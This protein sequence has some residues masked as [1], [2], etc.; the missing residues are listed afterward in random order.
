MAENRFSK[1]ATG[2]NRFQQYQA[3]VLSPE[4]IARREA[5]L[6]KRD[7]LDAS[8]QDSTLGGMAS[9]IGS[10]LDDNVRLAANGISFGFLDKA[11]GAEDRAK[12]NAARERQGVTG[13]ASE[14]L[15]SMALP[16][17]AA[18]AG[19]SVANIPLRGA[20]LAAPTV[21][22]AGYG[23]LSALGNDK[24]VGEGAAWGAGLGMLG[25]AVGA[26]VNKA[27][28]MFNKPKVPTLEGLTAQKTAAYDAV[29]ASGAQYTPEQL[30]ALRTGIADDMAAGD[31]TAGLNDKVI[32]T[33]GLV[34][35][36]LG[37]GPMTLSEVDRARQ[38]VNRK[39]FDNA[40]SADDA[41]LGRDI[42]SNFDEFLDATPPSIGGDN[43]AALESLKS[44]RS[45][46]KRLSKSEIIAD[47]LDR[48]ERGAAVTGSGGNVNNASRQKI[49]AILNNKRLS[50]Q[51]S[52]EELAMMDKI[53]RGTTVGNRARLVGKLSPSG[54]GLMAALGI[55]G[56]MT[57]PYLGIPALAGVVAKGIGDRSTKKLTDEIMKSVL[58]GGQYKA[59]TLPPQ[60]QENIK[61][62]LK[63]LM[64]GGTTTAV[65]N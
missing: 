64:I 20:A 38:I 59:K 49:N 34:D 53:A 3:P 54:N 18:R 33:S 50:R 10:A 28:S 9:G 11:L 47:A 31:M 55:G 6:A 45:L 42:L 13:M 40:P 36:K 2:G 26:G 58:S 21:E 57:N 43:A 17:G 37:G 15:G 16:M 48:A 25:Q 1:F 30:Q 52:K 29:D 46:N 60:T 8:I 51:F 44:A 5:L 22:G 39:L 4:D 27:Y 63:A 14:A 41:R 61:N 7:A 12:T 19:A 35:K 32:A 23:A 65:V 62:I 24:S 56:A